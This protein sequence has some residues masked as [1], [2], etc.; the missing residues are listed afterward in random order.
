MSHTAAKVVGLV[1]LALAVRAAFVFAVGDAAPAADAT[2]YV[3]AARRLAGGLGFTAPDG[4]L[5]V[6]RHPPGYV[7]FVAAIFYAGG[8]LTAVRMAQAV[9]AALTLGVAYAA[10]RDEFGSRTATAALL[11]GVFYLPAAYY[12][13]K[14]L[15]E[16]LFA[17]MLVLGV[18]LVARGARGGP[19]YR[20]L[21]AAGIVFGAAALVRSVAL[22]VAL[23]LA[24]YLALGR[25][26]SR[27]VRLW[28]AAAFAC[29]L[30]AALAPWSGYVYAKTGRVVATDT[31]AAAVL[32]IGNNPR[33]PY[34][35][36]WRALE[37]AAS[38]A[39]LLEVA[40]AGE[41]G[42]LVA[43]KYRRAALEYIATHPA[44]TALRTAGRLLDMLEPERLFAATYAAG[45]IPAFSPGVA[46]P[47]IALEVLADAAALAL[48][49]L[50]L[51]LM[52]ASHLRGLL[53]VLFGVVFIAH[54]ATLAYPRYHVPL[55]MAALPAVG[56]AWRSGFSALRAG[57]VSRGRWLALGVA[58]AALLASWTRMA[59]LYALYRS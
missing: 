9:F 55:V 37:D 4:Q 12:G 52:P 53:A 27:R 56:W 35:H 11:A 46:W 23:A 33:A 24:L 26:G 14:V 17:F 3:A 44:Q 32:Y 42:F 58:A 15:T 59:L 6:H 7:A 22:P 2:E 57:R 19:R 25:D 13:T 1:L 18:Y 40:A 38:C 5:Y 45:R 34:N 29:G 36:T 41:D 49:G 28:G 39:P 50:G 20:W 47:T 8:G 54:G 10:A 43:A 48:C 21:A 51:A 30:L 31:N 16:T